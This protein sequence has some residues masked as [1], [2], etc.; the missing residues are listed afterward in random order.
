MNSTSNTL[1]LLK[2]IFFITFWLLAFQSLGILSEASQEAPSTQKRI[3]S[4]NN[5]SAKITPRVLPILQ[6]QG[7]VYPTLS[8]IPAT[9]LSSYELLSLLT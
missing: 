2:A 6:Q 4:F 3:E 7:Y 5:A 1:A 9:I 8:I